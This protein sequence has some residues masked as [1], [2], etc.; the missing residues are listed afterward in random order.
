MSE[1]E[2]QA[3]V[4]LYEKPVGILRHRGNLTTFEFLDSYLDA[5]AR[6]SLGVQFEEN[7]RRRWRQAQR[8]PAWFANLLPESRLREVMADGLG[9]SRANDY[10]LLLSLGFD[11]P[12]AVSVTESDD[13]GVPLGIRRERDLEAPE[14]D[15]HVPP[16]SFSVAGVQLKLSMVWS[17]NT[18]RLAGR[19]R[20]GG[21][22]VKFPSRSY[23]H[24]PENEHAMMTWA[25]DIGIEVP[26]FDL[27]SG[28][29]LGPVPP[30]FERFRSSMV[31]VVRRFD[32][33]GARRTHIEDVN[34]V[35]GQ[36]PEQKY[37]GLSY[38]GL[39]ALIRQLCGEDDFW[40][41]LR[42][43]TFV[44]GSGNEDAHL[45]NWSLIYADG[46]NPRLSPAYDMVSTIQ[47]ED[48][49]RALALKL[50]GDRSYR[51]LDLSAT[52]RLARRAGVD[53]QQAEHVVTT[54]LQQMRT[55][56]ATLPDRTHIGQDFM[57]RLNVYWSG[58]PLLR[59][60]APPA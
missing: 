48:L 45:K 39:G 5:P 44:I 14:D 41:F 4:G 3:V 19:G 59:R 58:V 23:P 27:L 18:L 53:Q 38:E 16:F 42:R 32:R 31:Y 40:E 26:D 36:W 52:E 60:F 49:T 1:D 6:P 57:D 21:Q 11:L 34:Q 17:G 33:D 22:Y 25:R 54:T 24:V 13:L 7:P 51:T 10:R 2:S 20:L 12:G 9:V 50:N 46:I 56:L 47:Y 43:L 55:S 8:V 37:V 28:E 15:D 35:L 30:E 29:A